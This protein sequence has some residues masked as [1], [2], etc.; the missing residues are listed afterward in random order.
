MFETLEIQVEGAIAQV[1]LNRPERLNAL[2][3][4]LLQEL[5]RAARWLDEQ[6]AVRVVVIGGHGRAFSAGAD[7][8]GFPGLDDSGL[9]NLIGDV[10]HT[11][12]QTTIS[13]D[14]EMY[15]SLVSAGKIDLTQLDR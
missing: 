12:L 7:L 2:S 15:K 4:Q 9:R 14:I 13:Q 6:Q 5:E 8:A 11:P 1:W 3:V 10:Q